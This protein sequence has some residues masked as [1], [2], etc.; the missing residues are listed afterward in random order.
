MS[1]AGIAALLALLAALASAVGSVIRQRS[2]HEVTD[3][4][5]GHFALFGKSLRD[6]RWWLG[7]GG[8]VANYALLAFALGLGSVTLVTALQVTA[9]LFAMPIY[10]RVTHHRVTRWEWTWAVLLAVG[11]AVFVAVGEPE[12]AHS[13]GSL[14]AWLVVAAVAVP[15]LMLCVLA[16]RMLE[17]RPVAA[18]LLAVVAGSSLAVFAVLTKGVVDLLGKG[19]VDVLHAPEFYAW[20]PIAL[21]GMIFQQSAF[22]AGAL[23]ASMPTVTV[24]EPVLASALGVSVLGETLDARGPRMLALAAAAALVIVA[25]WALARG[26]AAT[27]AA[28]T[29]QDTGKADQP[30]RQVTAPTRAE[31]G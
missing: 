11:L 18:V 31:Q 29:G 27:M 16:A 7:S 20:I 4:Q 26:K 8:A 1:D 30:A 25:T 24:V 14:K 2:A 28:G 12:A 13:R 21:A 15:L 22:R 9:L 5:V 10:A 17:G 6:T 3:E 19:F 23:T